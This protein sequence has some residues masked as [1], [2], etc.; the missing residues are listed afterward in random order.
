MAAGSGTFIGFTVILI[1]LSPSD[2]GLIPLLANRMVSS[3]AL[4]IATGALVL[5]RVVRS[6]T[7]R[8][9]GLS[10]VK[11]VGSMI[12]IA[13]ILDVIANIAVIYGLRS[14]DLS[15]VSVL[16]ALYPAGTILLASVV[17]K[18][19]IAAIQWAGLALALVASALLAL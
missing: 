18:E 15:V 19:R 3:S 9:P 10:Q 16:I 12:V 5:T 11:S 7:P 2:S 4:I 6:R 14:G 1:D 8:L 13:G 17:L